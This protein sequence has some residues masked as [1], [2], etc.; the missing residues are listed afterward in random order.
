MTHVHDMFIDRSEA[1]RLLAPKVLDAVA[2][3][4][5]SSNVVVLALPRGG[6]P[7]GAEIASLLA[8]PL[9]LF[10]AKK[11]TSP[12]Y[13]ELALGAV[14][15]TGEE[16]LNL[17][18]AKELNISQA[19]LSTLV[20]EVREK[21]KSIPLRYEAIDT[22]PRLP[23]MTAVLCDD[24][25]ATGATMTVAIEAALA[26]KPKALVVALPVASQEAIQAIKEGTSLNPQIPTHVICLKTPKAF[27]AV[28]EFYNSFPQLTDADVIK[29]LAEAKQASAYSLASRQPSLGSNLP[30][31]A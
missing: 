25:A 4:Y 29:I 18:L 1:G 21:L 2:A 31:L 22:L 3:L 9:S 20:A 10:F 7:I 19:Q 17:P 5:G 27:D 13:P 23:G 16:Y 24:G 15:P 11:V 8:C 28:G 12:R 14:T 30:N 26:M 6:V